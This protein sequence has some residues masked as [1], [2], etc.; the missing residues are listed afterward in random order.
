[1]Q[2]KGVREKENPE[3]HLTDINIRDDCGDGIDG[4][5]LLNK[6]ENLI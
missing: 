2:G 1:M 5:G 4:S 3:E 6:E